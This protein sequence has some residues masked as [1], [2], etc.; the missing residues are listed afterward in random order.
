[1]LCSPFLQVL[2]S[3]TYGVTHTPAGCLSVTPLSPIEKRGVTGYFYDKYR[4]LD[5]IK[6]PAQRLKLYRLNNQQN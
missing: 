3:V 6:K 2:Y 1:M 4:K 5:I